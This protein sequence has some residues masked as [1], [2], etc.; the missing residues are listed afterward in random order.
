MQTHYARS[1]T[2]W[3]LVLGILISCG[4]ARADLL[5]RL[6]LRKKS[7]AL[8]ALSEE[9][10]ANGLRQALDLGVR[11]AVET[12]GRSDGFLGNADVRIPLPAGLKKVETALRGMGQDK[13]AD[14]FV[15]S[16]NRAA[17]QAVPEAAAVLA[18]SVKQM[19]LEDARKILTST[20]T[21]AT[22]Y[23]RRTS[24]TNLEER[25]LPIVK[26][27]TAKAGVTAGYKQ[28]LDQSGL[29]RSG[30][31]G[32]L[33]RSFLGNDNLDLDAYVTRKTL[34]GLFVKIA[35]EEVKIR[36]NPTARTTELLQQVFGRVGK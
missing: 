30:L 11:R 5:E 19:T 8:Q 13:V 16:M 9:Q 7:G 29:N 27:A 35:E 33:S 21:A 31:L 25:L 18:D 17:E 15:T 1:V 32:N 14:D 3:C 4:A 2:A 12:L 6:G 10:I 22:E 28:L 24:Q 23:F 20:N 34:D 26:D 36:E